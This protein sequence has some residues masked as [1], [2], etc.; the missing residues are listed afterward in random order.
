MEIQADAAI[1]AGKFAK[2]AP[3]VLAPAQSGVK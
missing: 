2:L 1:P 3:A